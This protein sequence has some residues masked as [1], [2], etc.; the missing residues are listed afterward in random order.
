MNNLVENKIIEFISDKSIIKRT[1]LSEAFNMKC[2]RIILNDETNFVVKYYQDKNI[3][4][5]SIKSEGNSLIFL[6]EKFPLLF[7]NIKFLSKDLLI[8]DFIEH[9][10]LKKN[11]YEEI[12][13]KEIVKLH[14]I[15][16]VKYGFNFDA[17]IGGLKQSN[18]FD[19]N[20]INFFR[21]NRLNMI[22]E[23]INKNDPMPKHIN[24]QIENLI[25]NLEKPIRMLNKHCFVCE[26]RQFC[27]TNAIVKDHL[28]LLSGIRGKNI[29]KYN[30]K[31][32]FTVNQ[33]SYTFRPRRKRKK[34]SIKLPHHNHALKA[35]AL[36]ENKTYII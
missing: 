21:D 8:I 16:G 7:P 13:A 36:R 3:G 33:L 1:T 31:G 18:I 17:Q 28:C 27:R 34:S 15:R 9:N 30:N 24:V 6:T 12:L 25:K 22:F 29:E 11:D 2:E 23:I 19:S 35:L 10:N 26:F 5:N 20:W 32:I 14:K 4:F